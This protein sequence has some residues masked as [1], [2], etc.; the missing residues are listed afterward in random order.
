MD[1]E[2]S[3]NEPYLIEVGMDS[4]PYAAVYH[5]DLFIGAMNLSSEQAMADFFGMVDT[6]YARN[7]KTDEEVLENV[8]FEKK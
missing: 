5:K 3:E 8:E 7:P 6:F 2:V 4:V 1:V